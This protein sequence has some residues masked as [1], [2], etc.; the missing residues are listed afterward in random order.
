MKRV[1]NQMQEKEKA[2]LSD[3][4]IDNKYSLESLQKQVDDVY[5]KLMELV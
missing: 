5:L 1:N 3:F 2:G 4:V